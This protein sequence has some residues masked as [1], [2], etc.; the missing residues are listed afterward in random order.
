ME[1]PKQTDE[2]KEEQKPKEEII[3]QVEEQKPK[4]EIQETKPITEEIKEEQKP[5]EE[6]ET[7]S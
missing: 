2:T 7:N 5:K 6:G 3:S 1:E 4:E